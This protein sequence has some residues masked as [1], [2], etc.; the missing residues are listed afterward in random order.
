[1]FFDLFDDFIT[2]TRF[3]AE[4]RKD[5]ELKVARSEHFRSPHPRPSSKGRAKAAKVSPPASEVAV[6]AMGFKGSEVMM[7]MHVSLSYLKLYR[8]ILACDMM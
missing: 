3:F 8:E 4:Q 6:V 5:D 7:S 1:M 2:M